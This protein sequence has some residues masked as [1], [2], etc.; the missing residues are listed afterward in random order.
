MWVGVGAAHCG[1]FI[2]KDLHV[3]ILGRWPG[4]VVLVE[5]W[6]CGGATYTSQ[7]RL[8]A[9][10]GSIKVCPRLDDGQNLSR[11]HIRQSE[12]MRWREGDDIAFPGDGFSSEERGS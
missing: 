6:D 8:R 2:L 10:V 11:S 5:W 9:E 1:A 4:E 3:P 12:M 7:G